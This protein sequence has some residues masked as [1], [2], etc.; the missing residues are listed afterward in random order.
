MLE[1]ADRLASLVDRLLTLSRAETRQAELSTDEFD[2][3]ELADE[4][5]DHLEVL[6]E[7]KKQSIEVEQVGT[8]HGVAPTGS[9]CG[10]R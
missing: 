4:V 9:W 1:E 2:L 5:A 6:A 8:P 3:R 10:R 7:E